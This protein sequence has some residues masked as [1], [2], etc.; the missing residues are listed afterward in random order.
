MKTIS[1]P[2]AKAAIA[3]KEPM[4]KWFK[5]ESTIFDNANIQRVIDKFGY[6]GAGRYLQILAE[7]AKRINKDN[8]HYSLRNNN[9]SPVT[10]GELSRLLRTISEPLENFIDYLVESHPLDKEPWESEKV[11]SCRKMA[12]WAEEYTRKLRVRG[13]SAADEGRFSPPAEAEV[14][15]KKEQKSGG[16]KPPSPAKVFLVWWAE[17]YCEEFD[18]PYDSVYGKDDKLVHDLL[19]TYS[20]EEMQK[21]ALRY[22][23]DKDPWLLGKGFT[24]GIFKSRFLQYSDAS[25]QPRRSDGMD[26]PKPDPSCRP[27]KKF[28]P[29]DENSEAYRRYRRL[30]HGEK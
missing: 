14:R 13:G 4:V 20:I 2:P 6:A 27:G 21:R 7:I 9:G 8:L 19:Q 10:I 26:E 5:T 16:A 30:Y 12:K 25:Y 18:D 15:S 23:K 29:V 3:A 28:E 22:L 24:L 11:V 17:R 1:Y